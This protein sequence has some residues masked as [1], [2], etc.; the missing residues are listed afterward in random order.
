MSSLQ[1]QSA[2]IIC[3]NREL[4]N[5]GYVV[6]INVD[7]SEQKINLNVFTTLSND[8]TVATA[9]PNSRFTVG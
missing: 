9:A 1:F 7:G 8:L 3:I 6:V 2:F 5:E 4:D